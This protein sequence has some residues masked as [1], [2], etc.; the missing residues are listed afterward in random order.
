[1][2]ERD[3]LEERLVHL[4]LLEGRLEDD[5]P[6]RRP[7]HRP[8]G[9]ASGHSLKHAKSGRIERIQ[10]YN[11]YYEQSPPIKHFPGSENNV[12]KCSAA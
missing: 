9:A 2:E 5:P 10:K 7:V 4:P 3:L 1:M 6:E 11:P 8:Q 12:L